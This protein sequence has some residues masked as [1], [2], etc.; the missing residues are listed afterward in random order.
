[1]ASVNEKVAG[2]LLAGSRKIGMRL[3]D[4]ALRYGC[5]WTGAL[6]AYHD[7]RKELAATIGIDDHERGILTVARDRR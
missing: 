1:V 6:T 7:R 3:C 5:A 2:R 4:E